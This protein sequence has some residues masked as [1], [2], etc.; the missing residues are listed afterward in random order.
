MSQSIEYHS[1]CC[2]EIQFNNNNMLIISQVIQCRYQKLTDV[3]TC[4]LHL[5]VRGSYVREL[6]TDKIYFNTILPN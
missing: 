6:K 5:D 1:Y 4:F 3:I 2:N